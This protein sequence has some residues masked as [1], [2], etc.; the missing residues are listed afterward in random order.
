MFAG[1][2]HFRCRLCARN[3]EALRCMHLALR[4]AEPSDVA[5]L[6]GRTQRAGFAFA[7]P[8]CALQSWCR[9]RRAS[10]AHSSHCCWPVASYYACAYD[11]SV[12]QTV[13]TAAVDL[14]RASTL[15]PLFHPPVRQV[16]FG[17]RVGV[18]SVDTFPVTYFRSSCACYSL[19]ALLRSI[20]TRRLQ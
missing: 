11:L 2:A 13:L 17:S 8:A 4:C 18:Q 1:D 3:C 20:A 14:N 15:R 10:A 6:H 9:R 12:R 7:S 16:L 19:C 5:Y